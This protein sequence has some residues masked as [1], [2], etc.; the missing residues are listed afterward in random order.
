[1]T[2]MRIFVS[3]SSQDNAFCAALVT[4]L[5]NAGADVW[6]D[7]DNLGAGELLDY[8][9]L[10]LISRPVFIVI[11]S[12]PAFAS[13]WVRDECQWA[14]LRAEREPTRLLLPVVAQPIESSDFDAMPYLEGFR[15]VEAPGHHPHS[16]QD[17]I[18]Q[19]LQLLGLVPRGGSEPLT[20]DSLMVLGTAFNTQRRFQEAAEVFEQVVALSPDRFE[21]WAS[22]GL[23]YARQARWSEALRAFEHTT[24]LRADNAKAWSD[25]SAALASLGQMDAAW[26]A[27]QRAMALNSTNAFIWGNRTGIFMLER[28]YDEALEAIERAIALGPDNAIAWKLKGDV[29]TYLKRSQEALVAFERATTLDP[30]NDGAWGD[31]AGVLFGLKQSARALE[32]ADKAIALNPNVGLYWAIRGGALAHQARLQEANDALNRAL[33]LGVPPAVRD[34]VTGLNADMGGLTERLRRRLNR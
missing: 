28:R 3:H 12:K 8:I 7:Q 33:A 18:A 22:L 26:Q 9:S 11:L 10:E 34:R 15:R 14:Y 27:D 4:A 20:A 30:S 31:M 5:R 19:T 1:M 13:K 29:L 25:K 21:A 23:A 24:A 32:T 16:P 17:A 6:F 2:E